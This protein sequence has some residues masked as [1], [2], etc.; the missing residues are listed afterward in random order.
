MEF[1][2]IITL[3]IFVIVFI[4]LN[5]SILKTTHYIVKSKKISSKMD[6]YKILQLSDLHRKVFGKNN[7]RLIKKVDKIKPDIVVMTGDMVY[8]HSNNYNNLL[9]LTKELSS[10]YK[11]Y[12]ILGNHEL[13][14]NY[15]DLKRLKSKL[16][17]VGVILL[18]D[19]YIDLDE[20]V[21]LYGLD[22]KFNMEPKNISNILNKKYERIVK[23]AIGV[24]DENRFNILLTHDPLNYLLYDKL[25]YDLVFSGHVHGGVIRLFGVG[26][27]SPRRKLFPKYSAGLYNGENGKLIVSR[28]LGGSSL[29][30]RLFNLPQIICVT[31]KKDND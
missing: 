28:G 17:E 12:Y 31:L 13:R 22:F 25:K 24:V 16:E 15:N 9:N 6:G 23:R 20:S 3:I 10:R 30:I 14:Q 19:T 5:E 11:V 2:I 26:I 1:L 18:S 21:R 29:K 27:F 8:K 4:Y 7:K